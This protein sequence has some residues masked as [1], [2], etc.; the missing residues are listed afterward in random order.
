MSLE[1][2]R[3]FLVES[4]KLPELPK[5]GELEQTYA[6]ASAFCLRLRKE[7]NHYTLTLKENTS[8]PSKLEY[9]LPLSEQEA[10]DFLKVADTHKRLEKTRH[11]L[12]YQGHQWT[13]DCFKG[14]YQGLC[15]AEIELETPDEHFQAPPWL[16]RE[17]TCDNQYSNHVLAQ[18]L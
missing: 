7:N 2:E 11:F 8:S 18:K 15:L 6:R 17:I 1:T 9:H 14:P 5:G 13:L 3:R 12:K 4:E 10:L 16:G